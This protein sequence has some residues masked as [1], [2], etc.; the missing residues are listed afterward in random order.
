MALAAR[1]DLA[2]GMITEPFE[3]WAERWPDRAVEALRL[4]P[5]LPPDAG[6][7]LLVH[8]VRGGLSPADEATVRAWQDPGRSEHALFLGAL[9]ELVAQKKITRRVALDLLEPSLFGEWNPASLAWHSLKQ[10][11]KGGDQR[12]L[13]LLGRLVADPRPEMRMAVAHYLAATGG[14]LLSRFGPLLLLNAL[15]TDLAHAGVIHNL[16]LLLARH[17]HGAPEFVGPYLEQWV[18]RHPQVD[19]REL[20]HTSFKSTAHHVQAQHPH[21]WSRLAGTWLAGSPK[22]F[23]IADHLLADH[24]DAVFAPTPMVEAQYAHLIGRILCTSVGGTVQ[25]A[26]L[27]QLEPGVTAAGHV[28]IL[29]DACRELAVNYPGACQAFEASHAVTNPHMVAALRDTREAY[30]TPRLDRTA[31]LE[32]APPLERRRRWQAHARRAQR[33]IQERVTAE[34]DF[35]FTQLAT[36]VSVGR[37][38][39]W[40]VTQHDGTLG[41]V[42]AFSRFSHEFEFARL[43]LLEP[44]DATRRR[45][46]RLHESN[47][48]AEL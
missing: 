10:F 44:E 6:L 25:L 28:Q 20:L 19:A 15:D 26:L 1:G 34:G 31:L 30:F 24:H 23:H 9:S 38:E 32:F 4:R 45:Y 18:D 29:Q 5:D 41:G 17:S 46:E 16:D 8:A 35:V 13:S 7:P 11:L 39:F 37:G 21:L 33:A 43:E 40:S 42:Q 2:A 14:N 47:P 12:S 27:A 22:L 3:R 48:E 36:S